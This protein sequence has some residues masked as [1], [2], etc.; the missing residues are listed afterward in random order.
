MY[1]QNEYLNLLFIFIT[2]FER[3]LEG[4]QKVQ[5]WPGGATPEPSVYLPDIIQREL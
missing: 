2:L 5:W 1:F 3:D 4:I